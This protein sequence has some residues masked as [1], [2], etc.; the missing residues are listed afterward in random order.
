MVPLWII[1]SLPN[2]H[3]LHIFIFE[4]SVKMKIPRIHLRWRRNPL[5]GPAQRL[6]FSFVVVFV[7]FV[8]LC[9]PKSCFPKPCFQRLYFL[10]VYWGVNCWVQTLQ[11]LLSCRIIRAFGA[12]CSCRRCLFRLIVQMYNLD[13]QVSHGFGAAKHFMPLPHTV[14]GSNKSTSEIWNY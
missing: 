12:C 10:K 3:E 2:L 11:S 14:V 5:Q 7:C 4:F 6:V 9:F 13:A 8:K 1:I